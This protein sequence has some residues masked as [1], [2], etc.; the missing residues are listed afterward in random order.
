MPDNGSVVSKATDTLQLKKKNM[1]RATHIYMYNR[2][3][4]LRT[5]SQDKPFE[6][7]CVHMYLC[8]LAKHE[9]LSCIHVHALMQTDSR[10]YPSEEF[11]V[12]RGGLGMS[13]D[14]GCGSLDAKSNL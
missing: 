1:E 9:M 3:S 5:K 14:G 13:R 12:D 7:S 11:A 8:Q 10:K 2:E 4:S 6:L